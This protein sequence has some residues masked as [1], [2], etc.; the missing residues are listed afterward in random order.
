MAWIKIATIMPIPFIIKAENLRLILNFSLTYAT[1]AS[2]KF[3]IDE[4]P[5]K[6]TAI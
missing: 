5:A 6:R 3:I 2:Y 1:G 4:K